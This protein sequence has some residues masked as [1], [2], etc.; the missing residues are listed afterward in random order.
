MER[1]MSGAHQGNYKNYLDAAHQTD[2]WLQD[3]WNS[4]QSDTNY[5]NKTALFITV[6][7]GRGNN[8]Q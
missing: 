5:K 1:Q 7:H 3:I 8:N 4:L 2:K 6:D